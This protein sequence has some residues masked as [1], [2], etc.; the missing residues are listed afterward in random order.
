MIQVKIEITNS[1]F[2]RLQSNKIFRVDVAK[3]RYTR[4]VT[5]LAEFLL[6]KFV[7]NVQNNCM[8][9]DLY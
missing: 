6:Y 4:R 2:S 1:S 7:T 8:L 3:S 9:H 5:I